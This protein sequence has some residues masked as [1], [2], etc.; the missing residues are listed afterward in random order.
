M[1][2]N[3]LISIFFGTLTFVLVSTNPQPKKIPLLYK[4]I[5]FL[6]LF[7]MAVLVLRQIGQAGTV[8]YL[9]VMLLFLILTN[10]QH[11]M[12]ACICALCGYFIAIMINYLLLMGASLLF[13]LDI[14]AISSVYYLP[15]SLI[16]MV[17][18]G[19]VTW[20]FGYLLRSRVKIQ[21]LKVNRMM[22]LVIC[23]NL[24]ICVTLHLFHVINGE[25]LGYS[26]KIISFN[27]ILFFLYFLLSSVLLSFSIASIKKEEAAKHKLARFEAMEGYTQTLETLYNQMRAFKHD[28]TNIL[29]TMACY[30]EEKD[31]EGLHGYFNEHILPTGQEFRLKTYPV[32]A[33]TNI[34]IL[35]LKSLLYTK[36]LQALAQDLV[37]TMDIPYK[38][39]NVSMDVIDL[40]RIL[41]I[42][43]DNALEAA[44]ASQKKELY[45]G[46]L[47]EEKSCIFSI[48]NSCD[49]EGI[50]MG[51]LGTPGY[52]T[53]GKDRGIGL[54]NVNKILEKYPSVLLNTQWKDNLFSQKLEIPC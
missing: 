28:Y 1:S 15:F 54:A 33:L 32:G 31:Y 4:G 47:Q 5:L 35:E 21:E 27:G 7:S 12:L 44:G 2:F 24:L 13:H 50:S 17:L 34:S 41:G 3:V 49:T 39:D 51:C 30:L 11:R 8:A 43:L 23:L 37:L 26:A 25:R 52:S 48:I 40:T 22:V 20:I 29:T 18:S 42:F 36:V 16:F 14:S 9:V 53:K 45:I 10:K 38:V 46:I 19:G 6:I